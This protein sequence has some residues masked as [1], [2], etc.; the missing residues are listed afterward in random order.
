[1]KFSPKHYW[2]IFREG[3]SQ[4]VRSYPV[5]LAL[6]AYA[7]AVWFAA[8]EAEWSQGYC[9]AAVVPLF[10][11]LALAVNR[12]AGGGAWRRVYWVSWMPLIPLSVW[13][14]LNGWIGST[15]YL[16]SLLILSPLALLLCRRGARNERFVSDTLVWLRSLLL[17]E[18]FANVALGLFA[19]ILFSTTYIF[20]LRGDWIEH[21]W[22]YAVIL[23]ESLAA[24]CLF[25]LM[26][27]RWRDAVI[28]GNRILAVLLDYIVAPALLIYTAILYLYAAKILFTWSLPEGGV[29][30]LV[31]GFT[32]V[33]LCVKA[34]QLVLEKRRYDWFFDRFSLVSLPLLLLFWV[35]VARR[36]GEY[37]LTEPRVWLVVCGG[38]MTL[39][40][41]CFLASRTARYRWVCAA[42]FVVFASVAFVPV[43]GPERIAVRS[44]LRRA[45]TAA[46]RLDLL[47]PDG[48]LQ[49]DAFRQIDSARK[50][51]FRTFYEAADYVAD[52]DTVLFGQFGVPMR[53][54][55]AA[56]PQAY[57][58]YVIY[59]WNRA[60]DTVEVVE[61]VWSAEAPRGFGVE[62]LGGYSTLYT[63][64]RDWKSGDAPYYLLDD[65]AL[66]I[67]FGAGHPDAVIPREQLLGHLLRQAG[68]PE[69][70]V[71]D[72]AVIRKNND[73]LLV[74]TT[75][76]LAVVFSEVRFERDGSVLRIEGADVDV[77]L[78][79]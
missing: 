4:V 74:Y 47:R 45:L 67:H 29:A 27:Q 48:T 60:A 75:P 1:M 19:A 42:A 46:G 65:S 61:V 76:E 17:A 40:V 36:I 13:S 41:F 37:G 12:L 24:P 77:V 54:I 58:D 8:Y 66:H 10:F 7:C 49:L 16:V 28:E 57:A 70:S 53:E 32:L 55:R 20:G 59:G 15:Q 39:C 22:M 33:A 56:V 31:F 64:W 50:T 69:G 25:L 79:R 23:A 9:R 34:L 63:C 5:E 38:V 11:V 2:R 71:P 18:L 51:D 73:K 14:G 78:T 6:A 44:Q 43:L 68:I 26:A 3:M 62:T 30:Y 35:G 52:R 21:V 72:E